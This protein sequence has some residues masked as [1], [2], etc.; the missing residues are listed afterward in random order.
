MDKNKIHIKKPGFTTPKNYFDTLESQ[1]M[2]KTALVCSVSNKNQFQIPENYFEKLDDRLQNKPSLKNLQPKIISIFRTK[3]FR[4]AAGIAAV[5]LVFISIFRFQQTNNSAA[6]TISEIENYIENG[7][8]NISYFDFETL[9]TDEILEET[10]F[11]STINQ[12]DLFEY[13]SY[14]IDEI[15]LTNP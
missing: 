12:D 9:L 11:I 14:E 15:N 13:L 3:T 4:Y 8:I 10:I 2:D 5:L 7:F 6:N 1:I